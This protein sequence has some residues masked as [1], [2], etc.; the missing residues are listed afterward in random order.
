MQAVRCRQGSCEGYLVERRESSLSDGGHW[1]CTRCS[2]SVPSFPPSGTAPSPAQPVYP[3]S[4]TAA[5][6]RSWEEAM[7]LMQTKVGSPGMVPSPG[8]D[9]ICQAFIMLMRSY[10]VRA[11]HCGCEEACL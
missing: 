11:A 10:V 5:L 6:R 2:R 3:E 9:H 1:V 4:L 7:G 8:L